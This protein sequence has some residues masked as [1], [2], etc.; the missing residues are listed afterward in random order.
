MNA[1]FTH[2]HLHSQYSLLDST[3]RFDSL[4]EAAVADKMEAL[5]ITDHGNMFGAL[6]FYTKAK[7]YGVK[8]IIGCEVYLAPGS[9]LMKNAPFN[10]N[11][12]V[13][14]YATQR[15]GMHHLILLCMNETGYHNLCKIVSTGFLEGFYYRPRVDKEIL[16]KYSE[17]LIATSACLKGEVTSLALMGDMDRARK[18]AEWYQKVYKDNFYLELQQS[19]LPQQMVVNQRF[20]ELAKSMNIPLV[21]TADCHY[22]KKEDA[23]NH[24]VLMAIQTGKVIE[25]MANHHAPSEEFYFKPQSVIKEEFAF[26]PQA[27]ESTR[28]IAK[29]CTFEFKLTDDKGR[30]IYHFPRFEPP[31]GETLETLL[32]KKARISLAEKIVFL[33]EWHKKPFT[34][35]KRAEYEARLEKELSV[36]NDMGF[37]GYYLIV[38]DFI[39]FGKDNNIPVGPGRGSGA[40]SLVA[41]VLKITDLDPIEHGL[42]FERFLNPERVS[43][44]DF[45]V[46]FCMEKRDQM[47]EYVSQKYGKECVAQIITF[48][49]LQ[50]RGVIRD[51]GRV[52]GF[53][54]SETDRVSKLVPNTLNITLD[55]A[56]AQ[57]PRL[58]I[59][60]D[61]D[62]RI[63]QLFNVCRALE[64][65]CRHAS[66]HAAGVVIS[67]E[68]MVE[69]CPLYRGKEGEAV[70]QFDMTNAERMGLIKFD[71]LGLKTLTF[72]Q[73]AQDLVNLRHPDRKLDLARLEL[74]DKKTYELLGRG[75]TLGIFQLESSGMQDLLRKVH[76]DAFADIVAI[77]ALYRP[78]PIG[79]GMLDDFIARKHGD[80][81]VQYDFPALEP[82]LKETYGVIVYQEQVQQIAVTLANYTLGGADL[83]RR[84]M[85]KKK[86]SEM[87]KQKERFISGGLANKYDQAKIERTFDLMEKFA[88]YGFNKSHSAAYS[89]ITFQTAYLKAHYPVEFFAAL[90]T[91]E[92]ENTDKITRYIA[93]ARKHGIS[94]LGPDINESQ[95]DFT[96]LSKTQIRFGFGA[97]KGLGGTAIE[98]ICEARGAGPYEDLFDLCARTNNRLVNKRALEALVKAGAMDFSK[99]NRATLFGAIDTA[100]ESG[101]SLQKSRD[102]NQASF[103]DLFGE[104]DQSFSQR[105]VS[106]EQK[107]P[108]PRLQELKYEK[109]TIGFFVSGHPLGDFE[110]ELKK[111][112][113]FTVADCVSGSS[114]KEVFVGGTVS[115]LREIITKRGDRMAFVTLEDQYAQIEVVVF[116]DV[117]LV[118]ELTLKSGEP[119]WIKGQLEIEENGGKLLLSKKGNAKVLPLRYAYEELAREIHLHLPMSAWEEYVNGGNVSDFR[120]FLTGAH[121]KAGAPVFLHLKL[122]EKAETVLRLKTLVP[123]R[124]DLVGKIKGYFEDKG[125][126]I[127]FR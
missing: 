42:L 94:V 87:Q 34:P 107:A 43:L 18:A 127:E 9:R 61:T 3:L 84:A 100:L 30:Q 45:D 57:E 72:L 22:L 50:A 33:E 27:I 76:P 44:P 103:S 119:V 59:L 126:Q 64:G 105:E 75:D 7:S 74:N 66:I 63:A 96:A 5:A 60:G 102:D 58:K 109:E 70:I 20:Q 104:E 13:A 52:F 16:E 80:V 90:L 88:G 32:I 19:G 53:L 23:L 120:S 82:I 110:T 89:M 49:K 115:A 41:Y 29:K 40:G 36:I 121:D 21:A 123:I 77:S 56:L 73:K 39:A 116:S 25:D 106:Y 38:A 35:E 97:I 95:T 48:G 98:S 83:L 4:F 114:S 24:E 99:I 47:I 26:C 6:E 86:V 65:L 78:G 62:P 118:A 46:D 2:L 117:Y 12:E 79:S 92:K 51:V 125:A 108:W 113:T 111:Y 101:S 122:D 8:P 69:H 124:R 11:E 15:S 10:M 37:A 14:P 1:D 55:E 81:S 17:G 91:V 28:E 31:A 68:P 54:P 112:T 93:D 71:F 67:N 85:G